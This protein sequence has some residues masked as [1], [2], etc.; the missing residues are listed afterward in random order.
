MPEQAG[1]QPDVLHALP[2]ALSQPDTLA[3]PARPAAASARLIRTERATPPRRLA[4]QPPT[5]IRTEPA[6]SVQARRAKPA[7]AAARVPPTTPPGW[8]GGA[9]RP[10]PP[11]DWAARTVRSAPPDWLE[12]VARQSQAPRAAPASLVRRLARVLTRVF[13]NPRSATAAARAKLDHAAPARPPKL[14]SVP[15]GVPA[16]APAPGTDLPRH[17]RDNAPERP[18][19][20]AGKRSTAPVSLA[21]QFA[22]PKGF[23]DPWPA[24]VQ[25]RPRQRPEAPPFQWPGPPFSVR[26]RPAARPLPGPWPTLPDPVPDGD[27]NASAGALREHERLRRIDVEQRGIGWNAWLS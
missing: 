24:P 1:A 26:K 17:A 13:P 10:G 5:P 2:D 20:W 21:P 25:A 23:E 12:R 16:P 3:K 14:V 19:M 4:V 8:P 15:S 9:A 11:P 6:A 27:G 22:V 18:A 7:P